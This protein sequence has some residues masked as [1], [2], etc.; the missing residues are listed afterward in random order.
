MSL[1]KAFT[2]SCIVASAFTSSLGHAQSPIQKWIGRFLST[3]GYFISDPSGRAALGDSKFANVNYFYGKPYVKGDISITGGLEVF[4]L[5]DHFLPFTNGN[6]FTLIGPSLRAQLKVSNG[7]LRPYLSAGLYYGRIQS[8]RL[9]LTATQFS[10]GVGFG[11]D[12][13]AGRDTTVSLGYR[14]QGRVGDFG[15]DGLLLSVQLY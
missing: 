5:S 13:K 12:W 2:V 3:G 4:N 14:F 10:P 9:G 1:R 6:D 7:L 8:E 11:V 15:T